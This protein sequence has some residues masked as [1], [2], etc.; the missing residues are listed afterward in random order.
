MHLVAHHFSQLAFTDFPVII[1][2]HSDLAFTA[3]FYSSSDPDTEPMALI[4][5]LDLDFTKIN[6]KR[7][8]IKKL[9]S[10]QSYLSTV[11]NENMTITHMQVIIKTHRF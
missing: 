5:K 9:Q 2:S 10:E 3:G 4:C 11:M 7:Q 8:C 1:S 6:I